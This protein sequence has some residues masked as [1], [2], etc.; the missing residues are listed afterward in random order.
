MRNRHVCKMKTH[1]GIAMIKQ[2]TV[3]REGYQRT[4][5]SR[6]ARVPKDSPQSRGK[7]TKGQSTVEREG[8][9]RNIEGQA[10]VMNPST[11]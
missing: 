8:Y 1:T 4:V 2:S 9:Q 10:V 7:G 11:E 6:E 3:E 5:H